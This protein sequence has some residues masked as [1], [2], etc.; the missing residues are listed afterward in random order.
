VCVC[1]SVYA[2]MYRPMMLRIELR[3]PHSLPLSPVV[4]ILEVVCLFKTHRGTGE[5]AQQLRA[6]AALPEALNSVLS[7]HMVAHNHL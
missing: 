6:P 2:F 7:N 1:E 5:M 3:V 4:T